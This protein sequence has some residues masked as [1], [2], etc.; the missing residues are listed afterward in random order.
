MKQLIVDTNPFLRFLLNDIPYQKKEFEKLLNQ[1]KKSELTLLV[2][3]IVI[4]EISFALEKY[5]Q[6]SKEEIIDKLRSIVEAPYLEVADSHI[7]RNSIK[8]YSELDLSLVD[9]FLLAISK[10]KEVEV[11]TF[12]K[13]L[14]KLLKQA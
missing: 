2:P 3:Q 9:C 7:F 1:A 12:D 11:F 4:F 6:F 10:Q 5:Y 8:L 14:Q 13:N